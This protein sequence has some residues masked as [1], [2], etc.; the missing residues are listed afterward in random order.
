[1]INKEIQ[2]EEMAKKALET[3]KCPVCNSKKFIANYNITGK[4]PVD[5]DDNQIKGDIFPSLEFTCLQC[6]YII[7][8]NTDI[9][10]QRVIE[11]EQEKEL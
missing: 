4:S 3:L 9:L 7:S 11:S 6:G 8:M 10:A 1:M 5:R 2:I